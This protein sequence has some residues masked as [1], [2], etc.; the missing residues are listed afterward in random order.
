MNSYKVE[1]GYILHIYKDCDIYTPVSK[2]TMSEKW[3]FC[4]NGKFKFAFLH[5]KNPNS[6]KWEIMNLKGEPFSFSS[7]R[8][9]CLPST[10][11]DC[12]NCRYSDCINAGVRRVTAQENIILKEYF[13]NNE[14]VVLTVDEKIKRLKGI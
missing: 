4:E 3:V 8:I 12:L 6:G 2:M 9:S 14:K 10:I 7:F 13:P 11:E 5:F 1:K